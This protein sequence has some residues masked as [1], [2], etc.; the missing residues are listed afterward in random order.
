[1]LKDL[2]EWYMDVNLSPTVEMITNR[3]KAIKT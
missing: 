3:K 1:M 2:N